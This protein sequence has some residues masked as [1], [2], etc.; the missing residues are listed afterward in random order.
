L[1][2]KNNQPALDFYARQQWQT[3]ELI[4]LRQLL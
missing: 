2:D 4:V 3:T 1:A